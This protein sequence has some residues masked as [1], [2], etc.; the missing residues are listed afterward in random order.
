MKYLQRDLLTVIF[1]SQ[2]KEARQP[3]EALFELNSHRVFKDGKNFV[4]ARRSGPNNNFRVSN[5]SKSTARYRDNLRLGLVERLLSRLH[6][7]VSKDNGN[8]DAVDTGERISFAIQLH[9]LRDDE[10][11]VLSP[12]SIRL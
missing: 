12:L 1:S 8:T 5:V 3:V 11:G 10:A 9:R 2:R 7:R 4:C 6:D